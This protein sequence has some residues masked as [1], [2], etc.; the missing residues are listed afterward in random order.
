MQAFVQTGP[1]HRPGFLLPVLFSF[2]H[3]LSFSLPA[4][5]FFGWLVRP[6]PALSLV[7][8]DDPDL[9]PIFFRAVGWAFSGS[10]SLPKERHPKVGSEVLVRFKKI[11]GSSAMCFSA[12][13][14]YAPSVHDFLQE[15]NNVWYRSVRLRFVLTVRCVWVPIFE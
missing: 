7:L 3:I 6:G 13:V 12:C 10:L 5:F 1:L 4:F 11:R 15:N 14:C 9:V 2:P 8:P